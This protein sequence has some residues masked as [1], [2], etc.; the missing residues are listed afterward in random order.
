MW[1]I[2]ERVTKLMLRFVCRCLFALHIYRL[3]LQAFPAYLINKS[4]EA[5]REVHGCNSFE[6]C[7]DINLMQWNK[8]IV[9]WL[10]N[11]ILQQSM[12]FDIDMP[13]DN[14]IWSNELWT[15]VCD[16]SVVC[17]SDRCVYWVLVGKL[18]ISK[19]LYRVVVWPYEIVSKYLPSNL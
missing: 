8:G 17:A 9:S 10:L 11:A 16:V 2:L 5:C 13:I 7:T 1:F 3:E 4:D 14:S 18:S 19:S 6:K 15:P 12:P